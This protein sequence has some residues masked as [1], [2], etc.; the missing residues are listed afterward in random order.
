MEK[1]VEALWKV[2][3]PGTLRQA[4]GTVRLYMQ[5]NRRL[6]LSKSEGFLNKNFLHRIYVYEKKP[7]PS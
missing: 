7:S 4:Q 3:R 6:S 1:Q 5:N 2:S